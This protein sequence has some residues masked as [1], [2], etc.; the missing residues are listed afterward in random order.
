MLIF[1]FSRFPLWFGDEFF[2]RKNIRTGNFTHRA[3]GVI[4]LASLHRNHHTALI[5]AKADAIGFVN[6]AHFLRKFFKVIVGF[7]V[8]RGV[9]PGHTNDLDIGQLHPLPVWIKLPLRRGGAEPRVVLG[10]SRKRPG[11][12][13]I[14]R[15]R[16]YL[17]R[18]RT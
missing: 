7:L 14:F 13:D 1:W 18:L 16:I 11:R 5:I 12:R 9:T 4:M 6:N 10:D 8:K 15:I 3:V 17:R 2:Y